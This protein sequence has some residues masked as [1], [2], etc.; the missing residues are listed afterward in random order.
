MES[1]LGQ[2]AKFGNATMPMRPTRAVSTQHGLGVAQVLQRVDLQH[3]VEGGVVE[4]RQPLVEVELDH[5]DAALDAGQHVVV[6][7]LDA[8]AAAAALALQQVQH[9]AVAAAQVEHA[10]ARRHQLGDRIAWCARSLMLMRPRA[11][12]RPLRD[13]LEVGAHHAHVARI[14]Q[15]E[16]VVA[17]RRVDLGVA[18][19]AAVVQQGLDDLAAARGREAPVGGEAHQ[20]EFGRGP[21]Q[22]ARAGCRCARAPGSK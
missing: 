19:V 12:G 21:C 20:Q 13:A 17:V 11:C 4:H 2:C 5:V 18:D 8:V 7:D 22:R 9:R 15:Q 14:L 10:R 3:D 16:G 6:G 1:R